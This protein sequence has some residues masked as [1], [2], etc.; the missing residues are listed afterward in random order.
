MQDI[1]KLEKNIAFGQG[2]FTLTEMAK[3]QHEWE[4]GSVGEMG[5]LVH[6]LFH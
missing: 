2:L 1:R 3:K 4:K 6:T 5:A